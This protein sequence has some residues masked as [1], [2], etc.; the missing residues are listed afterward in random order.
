[1]ASTITR[2]GKTYDQSSFEVD[3]DGTTLGISVEF[4]YDTGEVEENHVYVG[5]KPV[6]RTP[7]QMKP[8]AFTM[9]LPVDHWHQLRDALGAKYKR[10]EF[11]ATANLSDGEGEVVTD[12]LNRMRILNDKL[13][14]GA[15]S[16]GLMQEVSGNILEVLPNGQATF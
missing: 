15:G 14:V 6:G 16:E 5:G 1:M 13:A 8:V 3:I 12:Q 11:N 7:G 4:D 9:K 2:D 10:K